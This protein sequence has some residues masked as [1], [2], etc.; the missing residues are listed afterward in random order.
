MIKE[1]YKQGRFTKIDNKYKIPI[2]E[3]LCPGCGLR[4][5][6]HNT[7]V[8]LISQECSKCCKDQGYEEI[9]LASATYFVE[10]ILGY[11]P[12]N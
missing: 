9:K 3:I 7:Q 11:L 2:E 4:Y 5:G 1:I 12:I 10:Q 8:D 6:H